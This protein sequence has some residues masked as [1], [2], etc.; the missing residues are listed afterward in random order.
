MNPLHE[1]ERGVCSRNRG[2]L[3][4]SYLAVKNRRLELGGCES[5]VLTLLILG[6]VI[7]VADQTWLD[8]R[9]VR[10]VML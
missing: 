2:S 8:L 6:I 10:K 7:H 9:D 1:S 3:P 5:T 4:T